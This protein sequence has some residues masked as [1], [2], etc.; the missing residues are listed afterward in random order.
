M[1]LMTVKEKKTCS[2]HLRDDTALNLFHRQRD[3]L[4]SMSNR[5]PGTL[6]DC[7]F[8]GQSIAP[9]TI[10][11]LRKKSR[12]MG[13]M[14]VRSLSALGVLWVCQK[15]GRGREHTQGHTSSGA[16]GVDNCTITPPSSLPSLFPLL[17]F[18][19]PFRLP[20]TCSLHLPGAIFSICPKAPFDLINLFP[21]CD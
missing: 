11:L 2:D 3:R 1:G 18:F 12:D 21:P 10:A 14:L 8:A 15:G 9:C 7:L 13:S 19:L 4:G 20:S 16:R 6:L 17:S 5:W